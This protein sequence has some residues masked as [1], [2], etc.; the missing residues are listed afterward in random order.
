MT[1]KRNLKR[2]AVI[3]SGIILT[4]VIGGCASSQSVSAAPVP[5]C[6]NL[7]TL[8]LGVLNK[9]IDNAN[10]PNGEPYDGDIPLTG[11]EMSVLAKDVAT[12]NADAAEVG[13]PLKAALKSEALIFTSAANSPDGV[14]T[15][16]Q[17]A[18]NDTAYATI[19]SACPAVTQ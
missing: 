12:L 13:D 9:I 3:A 17:A 7:V 10:S 19:I 11:H 1:M 2:L 6:A 18:G 16:A 5:V 8:D 14:V 4:G 15:S